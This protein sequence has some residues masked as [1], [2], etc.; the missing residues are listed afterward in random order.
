MS[1]FVRLDELGV[2]ANEVTVQFL[3][4]RISASERDAPLTAWSGTLQLLWID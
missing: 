2:L 1:L 3:L 4:I